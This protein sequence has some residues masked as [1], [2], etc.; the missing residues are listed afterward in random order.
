MTYY[1]SLDTTLILQYNQSIGRWFVPPA[2]N[3]LQSPNHY[4]C[5]PNPKSSVCKQNK[6]LIPNVMKAFEITA[7]MFGALALGNILVDQFDTKE[8]QPNILGS[9]MEDSLSSIDLK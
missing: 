7:M 9:E 6:K 3:V 1:G 8:N 5:N 4:L 2:Y